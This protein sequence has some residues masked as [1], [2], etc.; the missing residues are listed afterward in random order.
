MF[1]I[2]GYSIFTDSIIKKAIF[3]APKCYGLLDTENNFNFK[4]KGLTN[5]VDLT[6]NDFENLLFKNSKI[7]KAQLK[8]FKSF[9]QGNIKVLKQIY[10]LQQTNNKRNLIYN[11][12][13]K[14]INTKPYVI[15]NNKVIS[16]TK[17][18]IKTKKV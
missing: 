10:T 5:K 12:S 18:K 9:E 16:K 8:T 14:L 1:D 17:T 15:N 3:L 11:K 2:E 13:N 7:Q 4:V 6:L